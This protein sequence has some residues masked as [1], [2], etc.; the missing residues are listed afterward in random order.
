MTSL[1][2]IDPYGQQVPPPSSYRVTKTAY[3]DRRDVQRIRLGHLRAFLAELADWPDEAIVDSDGNG[4]LGLVTVTK[5]ELIG[6][7]GGAQ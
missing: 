1:S 2:D 6:D 5:K 7:P 3:L 4:P